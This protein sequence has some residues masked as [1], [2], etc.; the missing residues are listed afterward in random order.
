MK[1]K[2]IVPLTLLLA[3]LIVLPLV[4][5]L[6]PVYGYAENTDAFAAIR[7]KIIDREYD[8]YTDENTFIS[9]Q[10][11][12]SS[13]TDYSVGD[14]WCE[15][16]R[17]G[18]NNIVK[19][20]PREM[21]ETAGEY[22]Y[23]GK[24]YGFYVYTQEDRARGFD[25][26]N[27]SEVLVFDIVTDTELL[28]KGEASFYTVKVQN[29][30]AHR[31]FYLKSGAFPTIYF[32]LN[33]MGLRTP[34]PIPEGSPDDIVVSDSVGVP[35][36][37][38]LKN[39]F[40]NSVLLNEY[41]ANIGD[42]DYD[43]ATDSGMFFTMCE[44]AFHMK[45]SN[46]AII[47]GCFKVVG[48]IAETA[49]SLAGCMLGPVG[50]AA[51]ALGAVLSGIK[52]AVDIIDL[53]DEMENPVIVKSSGNI[54]SDGQFQNPYLNEYNISKEKQLQNY[55]CLVRNLTANVD[56][57]DEYYAPGDFFA[58]KFTLNDSGNKRM[59]IEN[60]VGV[61]VKREGSYFSSIGGVSQKKT[62]AGGDEAAAAEDG[63]QIS[64][65]ASAKRD[66]RFVP[67][68]N[69][70][71]TFALPQ[72]I[73]QS[74]ISDEQGAEVQPQNIGGGNRYYLYEGGSYAFSLS[75]NQPTSPIDL[76]QKTVFTL[77]VNEWHPSLITGQ[78]VNVSLQPGEY[79]LYSFADGTAQCYSAS[80]SGGAGNIDY[81]DGDFEKTASSASG[82]LSFK[83]DDCGFVVIRNT[84]DGA[85]DY[86]LK[87][88]TEDT[89]V[90]GVYHITLN[91]TE[92]R[93]LNLAPRW[94]HYR[95][96]VSAEETVQVT[97]YC[98]DGSY[99]YNPYASSS[100]IY[101]CNFTQYF[102]Y[103]MLVSPVG[104]VDTVKISFIYTPIDESFSFNFNDFFE[105]TVRYTGADALT[106]AVCEITVGDMPTAY[107]AD[108]CD[109]TAAFDLACIANLDNFKIRYSIS[110]SAGG[111]V[112]TRRADTP[113]Y[114]NNSASGCINV[115]NKTVRLCLTTKNFESSY[116]FPAN[117][118]TVYFSPG[119]YGNSAFKFLSDEVKVVLDNA[120]VNGQ[121][122]RDVFS[123][124]KIRMYFVGSSKI[125][126][127]DGNSGVDGAQGG[128]IFNGGDG[129]RG[130]FPDGRNAVICNSLHIDCFKVTN[131]QPTAGFKLVLQGGSGGN[132]GN[133]GNGKDG[134]RGMDGEDY[135]LTVNA[136]DGGAGGKGGNGAKGGKAGLAALCGN[137]TVD[138][139][140]LSAQTV[141]LANGTAG[142][143]GN[144]GNGGN[145][146]DGG[147]AGKSINP[148]D[149]LPLAL[150]GRGGS[151]G[152]GGKGG[153]AADAVS[154]TLNGTV[155]IIAGTAGADG[156]NGI[157]G[158]AGKDEESTL[159][160]PPPHVHSWDIV[161]MNE[162]GLL[163]YCHGCGE[164]TYM[165]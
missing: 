118:K 42:A 38:Q 65:L 136:D 129:T 18:D 40:V 103:Y 69:G 98:S 59:R 107:K 30:F 32:Y 4:L 12:P 120:A 37:I 2:K 86:S 132:G 127:R 10:G 23:I 62:Y 160:P 56:T 161:D 143:S 53:A 52:L 11:T 76:F 138:V 77:S 84:T 61:T 34:F 148:T 5:A 81:F 85:Q 149:G 66:Y 140:L 105:F 8:V 96:E 116:D 142:L 46:D 33:S 109:G 78:T 121:N 6:V 119:V 55:G 15:D 90:D 73:E 123:G 29:L 57:G 70:Y 50:T 89:L 133:G 71:Y 131:R 28:D 49:L 60:F 111:S 36:D 17:T 124:N 88:L 97:V 31:Y 108:F 44:S 80:L 3:V 13:I 35:C 47:E 92:L 115:T 14:S 141:I 45:R 83:A 117:I 64:L 163:M 1:T 82:L 158:T 43:A 72:N 153:A 110:Y 93:Y 164:Y 27:F 144:G 100:Y 94:G 16:E 165:N 102:T 67:Q 63:T 150:G 151:G 106:N 101:D 128:N 95:V 135:C 26:V 139:S 54:T 25:N 68:R 146:G 75:Y 125:T 99:S 20:V 58:C 152:A 147:D 155:V 137:V 156:Q 19:I 162:N 145:G 39:I 126:A 104:M 51:S 48:G 130:T 22:F 154:Y 9:V 21:F 91:G 114:I 112:Y 24:E 87:I 159:P 74:A 7:Q 134:E 79:A 122:N 157:D 41:A 113:A